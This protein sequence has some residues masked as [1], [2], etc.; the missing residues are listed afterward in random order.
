MCGTL[1]CNAAIGTAG[2]P[3]K[4]GAGAVVYFPHEI[5]IR[6]EIWDRFDLGPL[7]AELERYG[8]PKIQFLRELA[9]RLSSERPAGSEPVQ[10]GMLNLYALQARIYRHVVDTFTGTT[11]PG[12]WDRVLAQ[13][14]YDYTSSQ[15]LHLLERFGIHFPCGDELA[16][17][18]TG[19]AEYLAADDPMHARKKGAVTE[20]HFGPTPIPCTS[21]SNT[22][23]L[24]GGG[25]CRPT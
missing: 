11:R 3:R 21:S 10:A 24:R 25:C 15:L 4:E 7:S 1:C 5:Q 6:R 22:C 23:R 20:L 16:G 14:G 13:A 8:R 12:L 9:H 17:R 2:E 19:P 18:V